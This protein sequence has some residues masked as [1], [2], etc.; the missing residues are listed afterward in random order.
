MVREAVAAVV[1]CNNKILVVKKNEGSEGFL[2]GKWHIPGETLEEDEDD[3]TGLLRGIKEEAGIEIAVIRYLSSSTTPRG[4]I[5][6][7]YECIPLTM[8]IIA[9]SD[10]SD[11]KWALKDEVKN[12]CDD[13]AISLWPK[14]IKRYF[15]F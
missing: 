11:A 6:R 10:V 13:E 9:G 14:E 4:T 5:V 2:S 12:I 3:V 8:D 15:N 7:W 1:R